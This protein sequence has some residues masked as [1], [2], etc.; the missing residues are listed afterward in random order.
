MWSHRG[1]KIPQHHGLFRFRLFT[2]V[3]R[4]CVCLTH[5]HS[6]DGR[7]SPGAATTRSCMSTHRRAPPSP[8]ALRQE[9]WRLDAPRRA[10][11]VYRPAPPSPVSSGIRPTA[12]P[13]PPR[14]PMSAPMQTQASRRYVRPP[15]SYHRAACISRGAEMTPAVAEYYATMR[16]SPHAVIFKPNLQVSF[17]ANWRSHKPGE[18]PGRDGPVKSRYWAQHLTTLRGGEGQ[19]LKNPKLEQEVPKADEPRSRR[20]HGP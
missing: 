16:L 4:A 14:R 2:F 7:F 1:S 20:A 19:H 10:A 18:I 9:W 13:P 5:I 6:P 15:G 8:P 3:A 12:P 17:G 11:P